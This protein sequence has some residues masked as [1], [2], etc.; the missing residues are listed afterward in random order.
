MDLLE[1]LLARRTVHAYQSDALPEGAVDRAAEG[2]RDWLRLDF[3]A[4]MKNVN[5]GP[6]KP[7]ESDG[8]GC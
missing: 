3:Q 4:A 6:E 8:S 7:V 1:T 5:T 2:V